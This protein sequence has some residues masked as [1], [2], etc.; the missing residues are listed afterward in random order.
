MSTLKENYAKYRK[1][2]MNIRQYYQKSS[3]STTLTVVLS[4]LLVSFFIGVALRPTLV[5][6]AELRSTIEEAEKILEQLETKVQA[7]NRASQVWSQ[8]TPYLGYLQ[9][10][11]PIEPEY[12]PF[13]KEI[14][15]IAIRENVSY[16]GGSIGEAVVGS[17]LAFPYERDINMEGLPLTYN[18]RIEGQY[19]DLIEFLRVLINLDRI[20]SIDSLTF[21][22]GG[23]EEEPGIVSLNLSGQAHYFAR[24]EIV[25]QMLGLEA[26]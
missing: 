5:K 7:L 4:F 25:N 12:R 18:V 6:I 11:V 10:S 9:A 8:A 24:A 13:L 23:S 26:K 17:R 20:V 3:V 15:G 22:E 19:Q 21:S 1:N 2:L 14:E 16:K